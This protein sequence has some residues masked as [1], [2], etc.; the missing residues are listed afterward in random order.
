M[1]LISCFEN[2]IISSVTVKTKFAITDTKLYIF[3]VTLS[4]EDD[5]KLL[6]QLK[7]GFE[8]AINWNKCQSKIIQQTQNRYWL[9]NWSKFSWSK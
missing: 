9:L 1:K 7:S 4:A 6:K 2:C 8:R 3:T 5:E